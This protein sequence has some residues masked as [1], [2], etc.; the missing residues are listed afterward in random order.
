MV[1]GMITKKNLQDIVRILMEHV[2]TAEVCRGGVGRVQPVLG[3]RGVDL[4]IPLAHTM[5]RP[6]LT[7]RPSLRYG[8]D[9]CYYTRTNA[10]MDGRRVRSVTTLSTR[11]LRFPAPT[12]T[13]LL[14]TSSGTSPFY[15]GLPGSLG[16]AGVARSPSCPLSPVPSLPHRGKPLQLSFPF[17]LECMGASFRVHN[18]ASSSEVD[19]AAENSAA[20]VKTRVH[21]C[22]W[23]LPHLDPKPETQTLKDVSGHCLTRPVQGSGGWVLG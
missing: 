11:S 23:A 19:P 7:D 4:F 1:L 8:H 17:A 6:A 10:Q 21:G 15:A 16:L 14:Q 20:L 13:R 9:Y 3:A 12:V 18:G 22:I 2:D 5:S